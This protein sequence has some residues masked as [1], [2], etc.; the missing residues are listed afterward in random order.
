MR[1]KPNS[2]AIGMFIVGAFILA[3]IATAWFGSGPFF[4]KKETFVLY[5]KNSINGLEIGAPVKFKGV[6]VGQVVD[7]LVRF[8]RGETSAR[9]PVL[10]EIDI[11]RLQTHLGSTLDFSKEEVYREQIKNG[12][13]AKLQYQSYLTGLLFIELDYYAKTQIPILQENEFPYK[14]IPT[15]DPNEI[16]KSASEALEKI[17][18]VDYD[19]L[20]NKTEKLLDLLT[21]G[22][23]RVQFDEINERVIVA[24]GV[25]QE[26]M[27]SIDSI[28]DPQSSLRYEVEE[29]LDEVSS[30][31]RSLRILADYLERNPNAFLTGKKLPNE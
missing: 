18:R 15:A 17:G 23:A 27:H 25:V 22:I 4:S 10:I 26:T 29:V 3:V 12:L 9:V 11:D 24:L 19:V 13:R 16:W 6:P 2:T 1:E 31:A 21:A 8:R 20:F 30:A 7:I 5:Y 14:E 28:M